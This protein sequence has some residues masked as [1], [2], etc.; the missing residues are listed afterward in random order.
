MRQ[1]TKTLPRPRIVPTPGQ[2][3]KGRIYSAGLGLEQLAQASGIAPSTLS[4]Y[5]D[6]SL[7]SRSTQHDIWFAFRAMTGVE[8]SMA[9]FWGSLLSSEV[10]A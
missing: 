3:V 8:I 5:L 7:K 4:R 9:E 1:S 10:A 2:R 6:G